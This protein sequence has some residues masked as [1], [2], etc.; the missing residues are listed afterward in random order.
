MM[1]LLGGAYCL[2]IWL[3]F[4]KLKLIRLSLPLAIL[5]A[6]V[7]PALILALLFC[8]QY[9]HPYTSD[10][11]VL[12]K[13]VPIV[14]QTK[15]S[16]RVTS[17]AVVP[18]QLVKRGAPLFELDRVPFEN[19]V[20]RLTAAGRQAEQSVKVSESAVD[21]ADATVARVQADLDFL[22]KERQRYAKLV[23]TQAV[24]EEEFEQVST[25]YEQ[26]VAA[27]DEASS[28]QRQAVLSVDL[29]KA[30]LSQAQ[31][32]LA[33]AQYDLEQVKVSAPA[34][35]YVTNLQLRVGALVGGPGAGS[36]MTFVEST[37]AKQSGV[38]VA[39]FDQKNFLLIKSDQYSEVVLDAYPG[40]VFTGRVL[41]TID[42]SG[43]GQLLASGELPEQLITGAPTRFAVRIQIDDAEALRLP[44]GAHG[45][46]AV[47][48]QHVP[49]AGIP[50]MFVMRAWSWVNFVW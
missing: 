12:Q 44:G 39:V 23:E 16:A 26:A 7:G 15:Q 45:R 24:T 13:T 19:A 40:E 9:C 8:A 11:L 50:V 34:D 35:G 3:V 38:V 1:W 31:V 10:A 14:P 48:T 18:N 41:N 4:A 46:A 29:S 30:Q 25:R 22:T 33:D 2:V 27:L 47:Y 37:D 28:A 17:V 5:L 49:I 43:A 42:V 36:V 32:A 6:S 21:K 20:N